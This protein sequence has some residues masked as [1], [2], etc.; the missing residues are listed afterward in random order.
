[1]VGQAIS[2]YMVDINDF[3]YFNDKYGHATG[4]SVL[5]M[6]SDELQK[7]FP[8]GK[9]YR[10]GGDEFLVLCESSAENQYQGDLHTFIWFNKR[11]RVNITLCIG[12]A[13]G[14]PEN[15]EQFKQLITDADELMYRVKK[16]T[17][18]RR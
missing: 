4:D 1:M 6:T 18:S 15:Q 17:H 10:Y 16:R 12:K 2:A 7:L 8:T 9:I 14:T 3:K 13:E 11:R 5:K